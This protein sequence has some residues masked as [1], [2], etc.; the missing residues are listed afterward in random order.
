MNATGR[1]P[2]PT[3]KPD[4]RK[5]MNNKF[6]EIT[7]GLVLSVTHC[8]ALKRFGLGLAGIALAYFGLTNGTHAPTGSGSIA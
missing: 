5:T 2:K 3:S 8:A 6:V 4:E 1:I 7:K